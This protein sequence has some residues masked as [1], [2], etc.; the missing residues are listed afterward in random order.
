MAKKKD[1]AS[2]AIATAR[3]MKATGQA[4]A[5]T[6]VGVKYT[7]TELNVLLM[8]YYLIRDVIEGEPAIKGLIPSSGEA[9][10]GTVG[11]NGGAT[12]PYSIGGVLSRARKY[13]PMPNPEDTSPANEERYRSY[14]KRAVFYNA[15]A[16]TLAGMSGQV[17]LRDPIVLI[18]AELK[19]MLKDIDGCGLT[20]RQL[21]KRAVKDV[22]AYGRC[23]LLVDFPIADG[24]VTKNVLAD[25][26]V[27]P[28]FT[29]YYPWD[30]INWSTAYKNG[31]LILTQVVLRETLA[32]E[33]DD[34]F[35]MVEFSQYRVLNLDGPN[36]TAQVQKYRETGN[37]GAEV[38]ETIFLKGGD[39]KPLTFIPFKFIGS[40]SNTVV[41]NKPPLYD[42]ASVNIGHYRNSAD[43][44][45]SCYI[46]GQPTPV[47]SGL[48]QSWVDNNLKGAVTLGS[49]KALPLPVGA[50]FE[51]VQA[52]PN[53]MPFEA[54]TQKE[55]QMV[56]LG[57]KLVQ[58]M[59]TVR[60]AVETII[61]TTSES[62]TLTNCAQNVSA[63]FEWAFAV[64]AGFLN[65]DL[66]PYDP[67][68]PAQEG[69]VKYELNTDYDLTNMTAQEVDSVVTSWQ[70]GAIAWPE[71]RSMMR[72]AG[73]ATL[74]DDQALELIHEEQA[75][76]NQLQGLIADPVGDGAP[77]D[78]APA[79]N[80][81]TPTSTGS[82]VPKPKTKPAPKTPAKSASKT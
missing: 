15:T 22:L 61:E 75:V 38:T 42:L 40:E 1:S 19:P 78:G 59:A 74:P 33:G 67:A 36:D 52:Q 35:T 70:M 45:E 16:R 8:S 18:P 73:R 2:Q 54:M 17:F 64:A 57:A 80:S 7:R 29:L 50:K 68:Q 37:N 81:G 23:G 41:P 34:G 24:P 44:E 46:A 77:T 72:K 53:S 43:Y 82:G 28:T 69:V 76:Q 62:S 27:T 25:G 49:R 39:G 4:P 71:M 65:I 6:G 12:D 30:I 66:V 10:Y 79:P 5:A 55:A 3:S 9:T 60:T 21:A 58:K 51:L 11:Y 63:V 31:K 20:E 26:T 32:E 47:V 48:D 14:L 13:L 56:A